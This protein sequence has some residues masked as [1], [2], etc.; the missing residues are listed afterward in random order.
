MNLEQPVRVHHEYR[1]KLRGSVARVF[2]LLC[3]VRERDWVEGWDP[4]IVWSESGVVERDC[5]WLTPHE[6]GHRAVWIVDR[7]EPDSHRLGLIKVVPDLLVTRVGI[8]LSETGADRCEAFITYTHT[9]LSEQGRGLVEEFTRDEWV[10]FMERWERALNHYLETG[11][12]LGEG[13]GDS[14]DGKK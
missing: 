14:G 9:A 10:R 4:S 7:H 13:T 11:E 12:R 2:P 5:V 3:P 8:E 1:Q 6:S